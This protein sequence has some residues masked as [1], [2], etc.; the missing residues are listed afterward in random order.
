MNVYNGLVATDGAGNATVV[1][2][3]CFSALN[4]DFRYQLTV[5]G[6]D[7]AQAIISGEM[8]AN[9]FTIRPTTRFLS[10]RCVLSRARLPRN[11]RQFSDRFG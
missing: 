4:R 6:A 9:Q 11:F 7:F 10:S 2:P 1:L 3:P 8:A 5:I